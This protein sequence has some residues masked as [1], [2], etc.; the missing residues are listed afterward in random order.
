MSV[1]DK[2]VLITGAAGEVGR[3]TVNRFLAEGAKVMM[4]DLNE[5]SLQDFAGT[6]KGDVAYLAVDVSKLEDNQKMVDATLERFGQ[7][8]V[9]IANAGIEGKIGPISDC[10][11]D[12]FRLVMDINV[13]GVWCGLKVVVEAMKDRGGSIIITSSGAGVMGTANM[14]PYNT[15]KHAVIGLMR[16]AAKE[17][18]PFN[19]R[20]NTVNPGPLDTRMMRSIETGYAPGAE[21][22]FQ[23]T[24]KQTT[25]M[26]RYGRPDEISG[27]M[28]FL[29]S[30]DASY[31]TGGVYM[32]DGGNAC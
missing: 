21:T 17:F 8:D 13:I 5:S 10:S 2:V 20:V 14:M 4:T 12:S 11:L 25:P 22:A 6:L 9:F 32:V 23:N 3:A 7:L 19:I 29:A 16:C 15:S 31:C 30:D 27:M 18:A 1:K 28:L 24:L 26:G